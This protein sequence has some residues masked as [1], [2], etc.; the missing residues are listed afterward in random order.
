MGPVRMPDISFS[1]TD[2]SPFAW[3]LGEPGPQ[4][5]TP[6]KK[7]TLSITP[8]IIRLIRS[9]TVFMVSDAM[10]RAGQAVRYG[11]SDRKARRRLRLTGVGVGLVTRSFKT[12]PS[13]PC[14]S[15]VPVD[16]QTSPACLER[17]DRPRLECRTRTKARIPQHQRREV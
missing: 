17:T 15:R 11:S 9:H 16:P 10:L 7:L 3:S 2:E 1:A 6:A 13:Q 5:N 8:G 12:A 4:P 14:A